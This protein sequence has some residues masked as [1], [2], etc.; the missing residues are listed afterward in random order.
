M[1]TTDG[2]HA[3]KRNSLHNTIFFYASSEEN[4]MLAWAF[5]EHRDSA[6]ALFAHTRV[7][8]AMLAWAFEEHRDSAKA[9]FAPL[10]RSGGQ[11]REPEKSSDEKMPRPQGWGEEYL[12]S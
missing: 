8:N 10:P 1:D 5:E 12:R 3:V 7:E 4:A 11:G 2:I 9:L 6:K